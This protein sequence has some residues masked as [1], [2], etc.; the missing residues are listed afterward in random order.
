MS[1]PWIAVLL[2]GIGACATRRLVVLLPA[3]LVLASF[4]SAAAW[5]GLEPM[6]EQSFDG[7]VTLVADPVERRGGQVRVDVRLPDGS[8]V[9]AVAADGAAGLLGTR[10]AGERVDLAGTLE[11]PP[12]DA[13]WLVPRHVR[14]RLQVEQVSGWTAGNPVTR[15]A[16]GLRRTL[17]HG[18]RVLPDDHAALFAGL[19][20]GDDRDQS[21]EDADAF[22]GAGLGHLLAVSGQNVAFVLV[23]MRPLVERLVGRPRVVVV[24]LALAGFA[25]VTRA[26]PSVLR[27]VAM[28]GIATLAAAAGRRATGVQL[29]ALAVAVLVLVDPLLVHALGFR[30][31]VAASAGIL[32]LAPT[33]RNHLPGPVLLAEVVA[34]TVAAQVAVAPLVVPAFGGLP[35]ASLPANVLAAP[36]AGPVTAWGLTGGLLAGVLPDAAARLLHLP[37]RVLLGWIDAVAHLAVRLPLG[38]LAEPHLVLLVVFGVLALVARAQR[39]RILAAAS[40]LVLLLVLV[41]P[42]LALRPPH[43][44]EVPLGAGCVLWRDDGG[45]VLVLD[46]RASAEDLLEGLR[47]AGATRV[48]LVIA[49][50]RGAG[51]VLDEVRARYPHAELRGPAGLDV[52]VVAEPTTLRV[53]AVEVEVV[54]EGEGLEVERATSGEAVGGVR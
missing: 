45:A 10:A 14:G 53:G 17:G 21:A 4:L 8:R 54:P 27:A 25:C 13:P 2:L 28:A 30:L 47:R 6:P 3:V 51:P 18:A 43:P 48:D 1:L 39:R 12:E 41:Q 34:V 11:A 20:V 38:E 40:A 29:L 9:E 42:A 49:R 16:N 24:L 26:E 50:T 32:L 19:V 31:S 5:A 22:R 44:V 7:R 37:T 15:L 46:G 52:L 36:A 33:L 23:A 35:V